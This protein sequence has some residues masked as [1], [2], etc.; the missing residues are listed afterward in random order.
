[1]VSDIDVTLVERLGADGALLDHAT[2]CALSGYSPT[3]LSEAVAAGKVLRIADGDGVPA[4]PA[5]QV[6]T[7]VSRVELSAVLKRIADFPPTSQWLFLVTPK[8]SLATAAG[9]PRTPVEALRAGDF[10]RV[11]RTTSGFIDR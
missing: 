2:F 5:F 3:L 4:Y 11:E 10:D 7:T 8:G 6:D 9:K 1:M